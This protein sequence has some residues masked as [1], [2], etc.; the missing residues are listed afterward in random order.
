MKKFSVEISPQVQNDLLNAME[1]YDTISKSI[2]LHLYVDFKNAIK[3]I[4][5][6]PYLQ[7]RYDV[8]RCIP[9]TKFPF[10]LHFAIDESKSMIM[11]YAL[12]HT[13]K[14]PDQA[15]INYKKD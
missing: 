10:M 9:L 15:W 1:Y 3:S 12:I 13:S 11:V 6:H 8:M 4:T 7:I 2:S 5:L 14:D